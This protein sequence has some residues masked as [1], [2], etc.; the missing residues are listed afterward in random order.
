MKFT[1]EDGSITESGFM[2]CLCGFVIVFIIT[3][4]IDNHLDRLLKIKAIDAL[5][6][7]VELKLDS[8]DFKQLIK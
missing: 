6:S 7:N 8:N 3:I 1:K 4:I 2:V 5:K